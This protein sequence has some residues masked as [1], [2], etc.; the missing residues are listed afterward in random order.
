MKYSVDEGCSEKEEHQDYVG[1]V[2]CV[3]EKGEND[4]DD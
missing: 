4:V 3:D 1:W 2:E